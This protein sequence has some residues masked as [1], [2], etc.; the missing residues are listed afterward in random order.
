LKPIYTQELIDGAN[1][2]LAVVGAMGE[3][4]Q[5][6][7]LPDLA[8]QLGMTADELNTFMGQNFPAT[9]AAMQAMP[10]SMPRFDG[11]VGIFEANLDNYMTIQPVAFTPI[12]WIL[13]VG[14]VLI[15]LSSGYCVLTK[16]S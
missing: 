4:M 14:G 7:M 6:K 8:T 3:E 11:F 9:A 13:L 10:E 2:S 5:T 15:M 16:Q 12:I 1:T